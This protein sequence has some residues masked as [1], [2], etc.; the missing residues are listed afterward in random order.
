MTD[1]NMQIIKQ[2]HPNH[3]AFWKELK[4]IYQQFEQTHK[5][6]DIQV[7]VQGAYQML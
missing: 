4:P 7:D 2:T 1:A 3:T 5:L 6:R